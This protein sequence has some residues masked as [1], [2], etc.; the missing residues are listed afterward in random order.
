MANWL[1]SNLWVIGGIFL[2]ACGVAAM[3]FPFIN[4]YSDYQALEVRIWIVKI[5]V[6]CFTLIITGA[7]LEPRKGEKVTRKNWYR[8]F[9]AVATVGIS[10]GILSL[11]AIFLYGKIEFRGGA[12]EATPETMRMMYTAIILM[13]AGIGGVIAKGN[14]VEK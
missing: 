12:L 3:V 10:G 5:G 11:A 7:I 4:Q 6:I 14:M 1:R 9:T 8:F 13:V 2:L